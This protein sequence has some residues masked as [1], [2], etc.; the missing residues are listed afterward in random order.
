MTSKENLYDLNPNVLKYIIVL[1][2]YD[3]NKL[4]P[5]GCCYKYNSLSRIEKLKAKYDISIIIKEE[6]KD[7]TSLNTIV[8]EE[9]WK[10]EK[11]LNKNKNIKI[12]FAGND[13]QE[14]VIYKKYV[15]NNIIY[16]IQL[17]K[18]NEIIFD[19]RRRT[20]FQVCEALGAE[21]IS[22]N[23]IDYDNTLNSVSPSLIV[24]GNGIGNNSV[25]T[26]SN[27]TAPVS[28][29]DTGTATKTKSVTKTKTK[30]KTKTDISTLDITD[31]T[32]NSDTE[33]RSYSIDKTKFNANLFET[34]YE[35]IFRKYIHYDYSDFEDVVKAPWSEFLINAEDYEDDFDL[36]CLIK[37]RLINNLT[38][39]NFSFI[40]ADIDDTDINLLL[41]FK[42][43]F[44]LGFDIK[45]HKKKM[46]CLI[47]N[48][49]F[50]PINEIIQ[51]DNLK[52]DKSINPE[53]N[54][55]V[56]QLLISKLNYDLKHNS[57]NPYNFI[58]NFLQRYML[59]ND[60]D[61]EYRKL[62]LIKSLDLHKYKEIIST[63]DSFDT[64]DDFLSD[65]RFFY[66]IDYFSISYGSDY[67]NQKIFKEVIKLYETYLQKNLSENDFEYPL[68]IDYISRLFAYV[69]KNIPTSYKSVLKS[70]KDNAEDFK[71]FVKIIND[72]DF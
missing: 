2:R 35:K 44:N 7:L 19:F 13:I 20:Y 61:E 53:K 55:R 10:K 52:Y 70:L 17:H 30:T 69:G 6:I 57:N 72:T 62:I 54:T 59:A 37:S 1:K 28:T 31:I 16:Y 8:D 33:I 66:F 36:K 71:Q 38:Y 34:T 67:E 58:E 11:M 56:F 23:I 12:T 49:T 41:K 48:V 9:E 64:I 42:T 45:N 18:Y 65:L 14:N 51:K 46:K 39:S 63:I 47:M 40:M 26:T 25:P 68:I 32:N 22:Y 3:Y 15:L 27:P 50:Y 21:T 43:V 24:N 4:Y 5:D 29:A 60:H